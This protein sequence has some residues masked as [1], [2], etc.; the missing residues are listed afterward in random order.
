MNQYNYLKLLLIV[1]PASLTLV[2]CTS[3]IFG[4]GKNYQFRNICPLKR[5]DCTGTL[6]H[7]N[8]N[9]SF[10]QISK[11][12]YTLSGTAAWYRRDLSPVFD[13]VG[14]LGLVF[15]FL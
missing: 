8:Y 14:K 7:V 11:K 15:V 9:Y 4:E 12:V 5:V 1:F 3:K 13:K 10:T 6:K 2:A